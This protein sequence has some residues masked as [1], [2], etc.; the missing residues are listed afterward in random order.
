MRAGDQQQQLAVAGEMVQLPKHRFALGR[1]ELEAGDPRGKGV[2]TQ[3]IVTEK[4]LIGVQTSH[5]FLINL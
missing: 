1:E 3:L 2:M 5:G 4:G